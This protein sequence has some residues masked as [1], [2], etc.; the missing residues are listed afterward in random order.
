MEKIRAFIALEMPDPI[1]R[2][3]DEISH[4]LRK[5]LANLPLRWVPVDNIHLTLKFLGDILPEQVNRVSEVLEKQS[6]SLAPVAL[7]LNGLG[8]F[9]NL[10]RARV[11]WIG[12]DLGEEL[13]G[14]QRELEARLAELD[15]PLEGKAFSPHLT[16][17][18]VRGHA[19]PADLTRIRE[20][21]AVVELPPAAEALA[22]TITL[23]RSE[24]KPSGSVYNALSKYVLVSKE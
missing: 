6:A 9:P 5:D 12:V 2:Q 8:A 16:L 7:K 15:I 4:G 14:F 10:Q 17:A 23:F 21:L 20:V 22:D 13:P 24:L 1:R 19:R 11:I 18:R 3:L